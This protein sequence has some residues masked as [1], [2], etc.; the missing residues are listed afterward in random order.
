MKLHNKETE[1]IRREWGK[2]EDTNVC[3]M[4]FFF[5]VNKDDEWWIICKFDFHKTAALYL[6]L[7]LNTA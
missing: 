5:K 7:N 6:N 3:I 1:I 4:F 2:R